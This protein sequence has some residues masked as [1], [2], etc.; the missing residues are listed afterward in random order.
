MTQKKRARW[1]TWSVVSGSGLAVFSA[2]VAL[3]APGLSGCAPAAI[4]TPQFLLRDIRPNLTRENFVAQVMSPFRQAD[5]AGDG[6][7]QGDLDFIGKR[8]E[9]QRRAQRIAN[10]LGYDLDGDLRVTR[11]EVQAAAP[12]NSTYGDAQARALMDQYDLNH[13]GVI[14]LREVAA[15]P[16]PQYGYFGVDYRLKPLQEMMSL[17][18]GGRLRADVLEHAAE[19][20]FDSIDRDHNGQISTEEYDGVRG[21]LTPPVVAGFYPQRVPVRSSP[22]L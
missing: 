5:R 10:V 18:G 17:S 20:A 15:A 21:S 7:D 9:A 11:A 13:D 1:R 6:L 4:G 14:E 8:S 3:A 12:A 22:G 2:A 19:R 16:Q